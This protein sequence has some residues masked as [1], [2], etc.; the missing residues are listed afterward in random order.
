MPPDVEREEAFLQLLHSLLDAIDTTGSY[1]MD[2][3]TEMQ[4]LLLGELFQHKARIR[5]PLDPS[6][7]V[8]RLDDYGRLMDHFDKE[9]AWGKYRAKL[10]QETLERLART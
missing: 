2:F 4:N 1:V 10:H 7:L 6:K 3:Q 9:S 8:L 5:V